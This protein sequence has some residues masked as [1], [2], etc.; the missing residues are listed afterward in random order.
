M[1]LGGDKIE[2]A[3]AVLLTG[4]LIDFNRNLNPAQ[5]AAG[6]ATGNKAI[7]EQWKSF[8]LLANIDDPSNGKRLYPRGLDDMLVF[9]LVREMYRKHS[10]P[11]FMTSGN[12][13]A[14]QV[15]YG[16]SARV[17][18]G[19]WGY[20]LGSLEVKAD[21]ENLAVV[22]GRGASATAEVV[23]GV[24]GGLKAS[25]FGGIGEALENLTRRPKVG[26][27]PEGLVS[28]LTGEG[29]TPETPGEQGGRQQV[30][31]RKSQRRHEP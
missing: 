30:G 25:F 10:L 26:E 20:Q 4:D 18:E 13:E 17:E 2:K 15:P 1:A 12:H 7:G 8:N 23:A 16:I 31:S 27:K 19:S 29:G 22:A 21:P 28:R 11:V 14:Y 9:S 6:K 5:V 3:D 24:A